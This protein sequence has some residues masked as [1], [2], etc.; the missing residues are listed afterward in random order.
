VPEQLVDHCRNMK[1]GGRCERQNIMKVPDVH[2]GMPSV[3]LTQAATP[4]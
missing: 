3:A 2:Q 1:P 4:K